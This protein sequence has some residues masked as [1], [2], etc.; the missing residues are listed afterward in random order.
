[1]S[2][3]IERRFDCWGQVLAAVEAPGQGQ[4]VLCL[5]GWLDNAASF[6]PL[7]DQLAAQSGYAMVALDFSGHGLSGHRPEQAAT[8][9]VDHVRDVLAVIDQLGWSECVLVGHSMGA[10][11]ATL[12]AGCYPDRI[13][14][15]VLIE[16]LGPPTSPASEVA[17]TL[18]RAMDEMQQ[19]PAKK[20]PV[21]ARREDAVDARTRGFG[22]LSEDCSALLCERGLMSV[23]GGYTWR[24]DPRLRLTSSLRLTEEQVEGFARAIR[25]PTLLIVGEQ[26]MGGQGQFAN[27]LGWIE[28]LQLVRLEGRHHLHMESP[29][30]V[31]AVIRSFIGD[32]DK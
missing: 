18:R 27:R 16:G 11:V 7:M 2:K 19:L 10:G 24:A 6:Y 26:G 3:R 28:G 32:D 31:A 5:H 21:Y 4:P 14:K 30:A 23:E 17:V 12:F 15:L 20:K 22:G 1:M 25:A 13:S 9:Y 29:E 8:H